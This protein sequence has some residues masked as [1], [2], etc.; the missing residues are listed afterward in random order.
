LGDEDDFYSSMLDEHVKIKIFR[1]LFKTLNTNC[2]T[3]VYND[4]KSLIMNM[5]GNS[6]DIENTI[7]LIGSSTIIS[8][9]YKL[10]WDATE[11]ISFIIEF[12]NQITYVI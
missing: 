7:I 9:L 3:S 5:L 6:K 1:D 8:F 4:E 2:S 10:Q 11:E 12:R